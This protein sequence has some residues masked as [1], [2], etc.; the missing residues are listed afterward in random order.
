MRLMVSCVNCTEEK[1]RLLKQQQED[2]KLPRNLDTRSILG[3]IWL[4][5]VEP[6]E[7][8]KKSPKIRAREEKT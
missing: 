2:K 3:N 6:K 7:R 4:G 5:S 1:L 8:G